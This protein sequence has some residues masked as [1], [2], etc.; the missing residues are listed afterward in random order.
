[1]NDSSL[2]ISL[3]KQN[4]DA[5]G[6]I[7][8]PA[9]K[10]RFVKGG[11]YRIIR[12]RAG[13]RIGYLLLSPL[14]HKTPLQIH[15]A[16]IDYDWRRRHFAAAALRQLLAQAIESH[17]PYIHL[18]CALDLD[19]NA[20]WHAMGFKLLEIQEGGLRRD[21]LICIYSLP[22]QPPNPPAADPPNN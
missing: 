6:F 5:L 11:H 1:M 12:G 14:R 9:I 22:L 3:M 10:H 20:F 8:A 7:P 4:T 2:I 17:V 13:R 21:R 16:C 19:A 15:Q 18:R